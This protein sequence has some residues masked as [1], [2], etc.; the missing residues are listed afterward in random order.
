MCGRYMIFTGDEYQEMQRIVAE[1]EKK[2]GLGSVSTGEIFPTNAAPVFVAQEGQVGAELMTWG[3][4]KYQG[5]G[6][7]INARAE[8]A[9]EK[10]TFSASLRSRRCV[11]P[12][13]GFFE[14]RQGENAGQKEKFL[15]RLPDV[16]MV[17]LA[18]LYIEGR[19]PEKG[20]YVIL[21]TGAN[22]SMQPY[23]HRMPL[24]LH[25]DSLREWVFDSG[26]AM[27]YL[28]KMPPE[29]AAQKAG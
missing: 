5:S 6:V 15:F 10:R 17:Y 18:G 25:K 27:E 28:Q 14:W 12:T 21:T 29:L 24:V 3:F 16:S 13:T 7:I 1:V 2:Y 8:T 19:G 22:S 23:H 4:P 26:F 9:A 20:R 11:I